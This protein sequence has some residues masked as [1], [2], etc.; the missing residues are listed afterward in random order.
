VTTDAKSTEDFV[1]TDRFLVLR[2]IGAGGMGVVYEA[3]D[4]ERNTKL[5][6]KT[7]RTL[8]PEA[9]LR[10]KN[11]F[12]AL[13][14]LHHPN[15]VSLGELFEEQGQ[16]FFTMEMVRG[17]HFLDHVRGGQPPGKGGG[18][19]TGPVF[20]VDIASDEQSTVH[21][22]EAERPKIPPPRDSATRLASGVDETRL[23]S[24]LAQLALGLVALH[25]AAKVHRDIKPSNILVTPEGRVVLLDFGLVADLAN[26]IPESHLVGTFSYMA[27]EQAGL[28]PI[29]PP[30]DWYSVGVLLFQALTGRLPVQG[31]AREVLIL[32]QAFE[33][34][35]PSTIADVPKDLDQLAVDLLRIDPQS[36]PKGPDRRA[37]RT[38]AVSVSRRPQASPPRPT[39]WAD[40]ASSPP[41]VRPTPPPAAST[42]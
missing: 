31:H 32:K 30:A 36:R 24:T 20:P 38:S 17:V 2:R 28:K 14:D 8:K 6:L 40:E 22:P 9:I 5:A 41:S 25:R 1:G 10:F 18:P 26:N 15:L 11:E 39:S 42:A 19:S 27:P 12:R 37:L 23:R 16:W 34:P 13:Q 3:L 7:L 33:P 21:G 4:R 35:A 29:G